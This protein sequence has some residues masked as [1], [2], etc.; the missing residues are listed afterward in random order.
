MGVER[1]DAVHVMLTRQSENVDDVDVGVKCQ[2]SQGWVL[3]K[4]W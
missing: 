4:D 2:P 3:V 1:G